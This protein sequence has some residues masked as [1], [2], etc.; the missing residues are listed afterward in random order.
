MS[1]VTGGSLPSTYTVSRPRRRGFPPF[2]MRVGSAPP[3]AFWTGQRF[4]SRQFVKQP[5]SRELGAV[6]S[7]NV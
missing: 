2:L 5:R 3:P 6:F 1:L 4:D 7:G